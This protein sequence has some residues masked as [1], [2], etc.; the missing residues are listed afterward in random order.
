MMESKPD[1]IWNSELYDTKHAFVFRYG[2]EMVELLAPQ[3]G[4]RILDVGC[5]TGHLTKRIAESG[6]IV[7]G[8]DSSPDMIAAARAKYPDIEFRFADAADFEFDE[9]FDAIFSNAALHWVRRAED[10]V[11][12]M[13]RALAPLGRFVVEFGGEGN[14]ERI[15][16]ALETSVRDATG[17]AVD[18][19]NYYPSVEE[20]STLL[21]RH[22]LEV[23][24]AK[25]FDRLTRL[26]EGESGL[27]SWIEM[28]RGSLISEIPVWDRERVLSEVEAKLRQELFRE[29]SW[30]A[31]YRRLRIVAV[32]GRRVN[33]V[34]QVE[35]ELS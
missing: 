32:K 15:T 29:G 17:A 24:S 30:W 18:A 9:T 7:I 22:G 11:I 13:T 10:A 25:L 8:M 34:E 14:V 23:Q 28:F 12:C 2:A 21:Q 26:E 16:S 31:D 19:V 20:Y 35:S 3:P 33:D 5:G 6:A 1:N 4:E 27:R